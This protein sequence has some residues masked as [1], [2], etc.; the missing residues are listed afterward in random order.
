MATVEE[1]KRVKRR[2]AATLLRKEGVNGVDIDEDA[3]GA[4]IIAIHLETD[5]PKVI[6]QLPHELEGH[7]VKFVCTGPIRKQTAKRGS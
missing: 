5:D 7:P 4:P 1:L 6:Q 2:H 3:T